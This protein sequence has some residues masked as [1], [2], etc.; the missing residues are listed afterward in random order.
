M[1]AEGRDVEVKAGRRRRRRK[2][3]RGRRKGRGERQEQVAALFEMLRMYAGGRACYSK[4]MAGGQNASPKHTACTQP[5]GCL[6][7]SH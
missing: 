2:K 5:W 4:V 3:R 7:P 1:S 6:D